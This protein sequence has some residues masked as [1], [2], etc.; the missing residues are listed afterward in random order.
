M[1]EL[2]LK[3]DKLIE[4]LNKFQLSRSFDNSDGGTGI[5]VTNFEVKFRNA[6]LTLLYERD[7]GCR[8]HSARGSSGDNKAEKTNSAVG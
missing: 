5:C 1:N 7:Y 6:E 3:C 2:L 4:T 8:V